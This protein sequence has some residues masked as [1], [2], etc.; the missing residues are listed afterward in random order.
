[1]AK[2]LPRCQA[3]AKVD[4]PV[5]TSNALDPRDFGG[6]CPVFGVTDFRALASAA[7][8]FLVVVQARISGITAVWLAL[9]S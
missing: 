7:A 9:S 1:M 3:M 6:V 2:Y 8:A 5:D 4:G